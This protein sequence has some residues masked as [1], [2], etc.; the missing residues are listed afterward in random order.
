M[1]LLL[2]SFGSFAGDFGSAA[3]IPAIL[4]QAVEWNIS[5][6]RANY[7]N[8]LSSVMCGV[9][10]ILWMPLLNA[11][12]RMPVLFWTSVL[13]LFFT[14]GATLATDFETHYAMR[15]LQSLFQS[16]GQTIGLAFVKDCFFFHE[17]ARKIGI[18]Y[19]IFITSPFLSPLLGNFIIGT[20]GEWRV[21]FWLVFSWSGFLVCMILVF[22][23]ETFYNR[24]VPLD[25]QPARNPGHYNRL[26]RVTG[27]WQIR[28]HS[29]YF[30]TILSS[31]SRLAAVFLKPVIPI[32]MIFYAG[33]FMWFIG[34]TITSSILLETP[35]SVG[36]FGLS[37]VGVGY[38]FFTPVVSVMLGEL[39]GHWFNDYTVKLY[40]GR[41]NGLFVPEVRIWTTY[42]GLFLMVPGLVLVGQALTHHL[43]VAAIV[44]GWGME[45]V[46]IMVT[47]VA[48][49]A[50]VLD[51]YPTASGE[52]S[53]LINMA[54][55]GAG[56]SVGYFQQAWG[57]KD[58]YDVAFGVQAA[59]VVGVFSLTILNH[60]FGA[61]LR[62]WAGPVRHLIY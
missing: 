19:A 28:N 51:C 34:I 23:D 31:Y 54:R 5:P 49:I 15:A 56:F 22:G 60:I 44:F 33:I 50:Y 43:N 36:G 29:N 61:R 27:I 55:V 57:A 11:W 46:G 53:A 24:G 14:L 3:G 37:A 39:F 58:G 62:A 38:V 26:L 9:S 30:A 42:V 41:H 21:I 40:A 13:G 35:R 17:H 20:L 47:S 1:A 18:W 48:T 6:V 32:T 52:V 12:G 16:V 10:G 4:A 7:A 59:V 25:R 8:N 45:V 2:V